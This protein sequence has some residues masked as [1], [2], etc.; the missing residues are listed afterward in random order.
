MAASGP[1]QAAPTVVQAQH[2][3]CST[4]QPAGFNLVQVVAQHKED[5]HMTV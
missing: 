3:S 2:S 4:Q 1:G 5:A